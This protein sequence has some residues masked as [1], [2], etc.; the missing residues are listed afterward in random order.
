MSGA[1]LPSWV[2]TLALRPHDAEN[3]ETAIEAVVV[4]AP[5]LATALVV[6]GQRCTATVVRVVEVHQVATE[7]KQ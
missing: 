7:A 2:V 3:G 5:D 1:P 4:E 6:A